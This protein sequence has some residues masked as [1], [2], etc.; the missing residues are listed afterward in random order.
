MAEVA[1]AISEATGRRVVHESASVVDYLAALRAT[2]ADPRRLAYLADLLIDARAGAFAAV[3]GDVPK[4]IGQPAR[5]LEQF[6]AETAGYWR[7]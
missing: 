1:A 4:V 2:G 3:T 6:V 5:T 7:P